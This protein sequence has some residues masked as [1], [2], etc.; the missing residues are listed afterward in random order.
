[1]GPPGRAERKQ[2]PI[3]EKEGFKW[4]RGIRA[5]GAAPDVHR[6]DTQLVHVFDREGDIH[7]VLAEV[8]DERDDAVIRCGRNRKVA[9]PYTCI[10]FRPCGA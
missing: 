6:P 5:I 8:A 2:F 4:L 1:M 3:E 9:D 10:R 7:E